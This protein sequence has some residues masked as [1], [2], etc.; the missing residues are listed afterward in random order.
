MEDGGSTQQIW[1]HLL[2][3]ETLVKDMKSNLLNTSATEEQRKDS[4]WLVV[5]KFLEE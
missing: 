1:A 2:V 5:S 3:N 4:L